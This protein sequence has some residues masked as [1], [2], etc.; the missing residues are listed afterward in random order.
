MSDTIVCPNCAHEIEVTEVVAAQVRKEMQNEFDAKL[1]ERDA[2]IAKKE[3]AL[4]AERERVAK[5]SASVDARVQETLASER[6]AIVENALKKAKDDVAVELGASQS[7]L[8]EIRTK[9]KAAQDQEL[10]LRKK[11]RALEEEK[12]AF[13]LTLTRKLDE[14][15][16]AIRETAKKEA[17]DE[18]LLKEA[19][20]DKV[21]GDLK[22][23][24]EDMKRTAEQ[25]SQQAQGEVFE[26]ALEETL[27]RT[28]PRDVIEPV[29]KGVHGGDIVHHVH[30]AS[31][32]RVASM[33]WESKRTKNWD[34]KWLP[35]LRDDQRAGKFDLAILVST[36]MPKTVTTF[37]NVDGVWV[38]NHP[39]AVALAAALRS[40]LLDVANAKRSSEG[41]TTKMAMLYDYLSGHEFKNRV[42]AIVESFTALREDLD[43]EKKAFERIWNK[44]EKQLTRAIV[45]TAGMY[46]DLQGIVGA[47]LP[48]LA[49][50]EL[51]LLD[52]GNDEPPAAKS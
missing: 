7:E 8:A 32:T 40:G 21:I 25:G 51:P 41:R 47:S 19:E 44:R 16:A 12:Q 52:D 45:S 18:R 26:L 17:A 27:R 3:A 35:K 30:D 36:A 9:L 2:E 28:F 5:E 29:P 23:Q 10:E 15:R 13:E 11:G 22:K 31:G 46:G 24:I 34:D 1:R 14:E 20:K 42:G 48:A 4:A 38:T 6:K 43:A 50:L 33:L 39:S 37:E 49:S